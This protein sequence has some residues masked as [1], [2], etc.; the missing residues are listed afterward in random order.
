MRKLKFRAWDKELKFFVDTTVYFIGLDGSVWFNNCG[1]GSDS[2]YDQSEKLMIMEWTGLQDINGNDIYEGDFL[3]FDKK[4]WGG[5]DNIHGPV[6]YDETQGEWNTGG[7]LNS[8][9][10]EFKKVIGNVFE[11]PELAAST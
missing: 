9:C 5:D 4:E 10:S 7:G 1:D 3:E 11:N 6:K 2:M 8:E